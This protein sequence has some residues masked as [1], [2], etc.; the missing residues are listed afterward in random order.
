[1]LREY[2]GAEGRLNR[3]GAGGITLRQSLEQVERTTGVAP[4][5][6][7]H[8]KKLPEGFEYIWGWFVDIHGPEILKY[9]EIEAWSRCTGRRI[10]PAEA[11]I[12]RE[13]SIVYLG[14]V[15]A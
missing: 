3:R 6:L 10:E 2:V 13:L 4:P 1:M 9:Q 12:L 5:E 14:A 7:D 11:E 15:N 8:G